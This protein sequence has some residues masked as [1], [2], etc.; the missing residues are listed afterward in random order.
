[1]EGYT[2]ATLKDDLAEVLHTAFQFQAVAGVPAFERMALAAIEYFDALSCGDCKEDRQDSPA[3]FPMRD[4]LAVCA[5]VRCLL[6]RTRGLGHY[7][8]PLCRVM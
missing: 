3:T 5:E 7:S 2:V 1:M 4:D 6:K 8:T